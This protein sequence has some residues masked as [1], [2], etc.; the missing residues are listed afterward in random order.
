M[1]R[2]VSAPQRS[3]TDGDGKTQFSDSLY[4]GDIANATICMNDL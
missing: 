4:E 2:W 3:Y 1:H